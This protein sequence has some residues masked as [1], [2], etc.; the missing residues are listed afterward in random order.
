MHMHGHNF[1]VVSVGEGPYDPIT[2]ANASVPIPVRR[3]VV[4]VPGEGY[5]V[6]RF[7]NDNPGV[8]LYACFVLFSPPS[9]FLL[10]VYLY[11]KKNHQLSLPYRM[12]SSSR[13]CSTVY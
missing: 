8:W 1:Q 12:A 3:D 9:F 5:A 6:L 10:S 13:P 4:T 11:L 2:A 7:V